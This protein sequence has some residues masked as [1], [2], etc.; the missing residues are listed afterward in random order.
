[1]NIPENLLYSKSHEWVKFEDETTATI[2]LTD[3]AQSQLS[4]V[5]FVNL[6]EPDDNLEA[7]S[8][9]ADVESIKAVNDVYS[10]VGGVVCAINEELL[11]SPEKINQ[12]PYDSWLVK[13]KNIHEKNELMDAQVYRKLVEEEEKKH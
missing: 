4:D 7:G 8:A 9:M 11:D 5:V 1:M 13:V 10:P 2:G 12:A 6:P 3:Y